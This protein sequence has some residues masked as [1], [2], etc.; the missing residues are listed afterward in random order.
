VAAKNADVVARLKVAYNKA[1]KELAP[2][3]AKP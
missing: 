3:A 2:N 1:V